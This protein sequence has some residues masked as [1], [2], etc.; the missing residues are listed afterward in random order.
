MVLY[1]Q[2]SYAQQLSAR[3]SLSL[4]S[5][6]EP[7]HS[8][9]SWSSAKWKSMN[10]ARSLQFSLSVFPSPPTLYVHS[11]S[12]TQCFQIIRFV[13]TGR[14]TFDKLIHTEW[15]NGLTFPKVAA[16]QKRNLNWELW[17]LKGWSPHGGIRACLVPQLRLSLL[18]LGQVASPSWLPRTT[19]TSVWRN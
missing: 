16:V 17:K 8:R 14:K 2:Y 19:L 4:S 9:Q 3:Q 11:F 15:F 13:L 7:R 6:M 1:I 18:L 12:D 10:L 5:W